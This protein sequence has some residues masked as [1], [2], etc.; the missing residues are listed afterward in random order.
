MPKI[1]YVV[2]EDWFFCQH[3]LP[4]ARHVVGGWLRR[5]GTH[6]LFE[7][8]DD[9][10]EFGLQ[11]AGSDVTIV[12]GAGVRPEDFPVLPEPSSP[13][14]RVAVVARMLRPKGITEAV[15]AV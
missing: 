15:A 7:N 2:S 8:F 9:P 1:L 3:F 4:L 12:G 13:P 10:G 5:R 6:Y 11:T 14:L